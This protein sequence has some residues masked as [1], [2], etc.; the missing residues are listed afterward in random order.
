MTIEASPDALR[1]DDYL[2]A[3]LTWQTALLDS[4]ILAQ[5]NYF[6]N[7]AAWQQAV[8]AFNQDFFDRW[9]CRFGG[10]VP[11]DG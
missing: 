2:T 3:T 8:E 1:D 9:V 4:W 10:G 11:L 5:R 7:L 6:Q